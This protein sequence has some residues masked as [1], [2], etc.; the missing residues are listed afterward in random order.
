MQEEAGLLRLRLRD[1]RQSRSKSTSRSKSKSR[2]E[3]AKEQ[4]AQ[5]RM[6]QTLGWT[7]QAARLKVFRGRARLKELMERALRRRAATRR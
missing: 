2:L 3:C 7:E 1:K 5:V 6:A 4:W